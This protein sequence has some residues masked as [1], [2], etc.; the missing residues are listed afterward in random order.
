MIASLLALVFSADPSGLQDALLTG[1]Q[2]EVHFV[3]T[4]SKVT[5]TGQTLKALAKLISCEDRVEV[6]DSAPVG[7][8]MAFHIS[9]QKGDSVE[10]F[11]IFPPS[12]I[13]F[14]TANAAGERKLAHLKDEQFSQALLALFSTAQPNTTTSAAPV[15]IQT[16]GD[17]GGVSLFVSDLVYVADSSRD[18]LLVFVPSRATGKLGPGI[19]FQDGS[20]KGPS[21]VVV[22]DRRAYVA[23]SGS[24]TVHVFER[25]PGNTSHHRLLEVADDRALQ[26]PQ[27]LALSPQGEHLYVAAAGNGTIVV[28]QIN[29]DG[30]LLFVQAVGNEFTDRPT[31][32]TLA[33]NGRYLYVT[34]QS[35]QLCTFARNRESG[36]LTLVRG[37]RDRLVN[38]RFEPTDRGLSLAS[39]SAVDGDK[40]YVAGA[41]DR[42]ALWEHSGDAP[43]F[44][45]RWLD[46]HHE[47]EGIGGASSI[48]VIP[49][50]RLWVAGP[51]EG[52]I[53]WF[54]Q[55]NSR[56]VL[57]YGGMLKV[58]ASI[59]AIGANPEGTLLYAAAANSIFVISSR[60]TSESR[61]GPKP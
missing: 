55:L 59:H 11:T 39:A 33:A 27:A 32:V 17:A 29:E 18:R 28:F 48:A 60:P 47:V 52:A 56:G 19:A 40:L 61:V 4:N 23:G 58:G 14:G 46:G 51:K 24:N 3:K 35:N 10:R 31:S 45:E 43:E 2:S 8:K 38:G 50:K 1:E 12:K 30:R 21:A 9:V 49:S 13:V 5:C 20:L 57:S 16:I 53:A 41:A 26:R 54:D 25:D 42:V 44:V 37:E 7:T 6:W 34:S 22:H 15:V 36:E